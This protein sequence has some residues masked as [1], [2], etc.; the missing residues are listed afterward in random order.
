MRDENSITIDL[1]RILFHIY[2][3]LPIIA[4]VTVAFGLIGFLI[5]AVI[6]PPTYSA[7]AQ[8]LVNNRRDDQGQSTISQSDINASSSLVDTYAIILKSYD[9]LEKV[10]KECS[11]DY[12]FE[13]LSS[14]I[15]VKAVNSTQVMR[16]TVENRNPDEALAICSS[17]VKLAPD[18]IINAIDAGSVSTVS[19]PYTTG[20]PIAPSKRNF[21][22]LGALLG[23]FLSAVYVAIR[24]LTNDRFK[25]TEDI[26]TIL[27]I[28]VL[29]VIP[30]ENT[31]KGT[32]K[33]RS[34]RNRGDK[35][36]GDRKES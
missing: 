10:E 13:D 15:S 29:G 7:S 14:M 2:K 12:A 34:R 4:L 33:K 32:K 11:L 26:R 18:A 22:A 20:K 27:D 36:D 19:S 25:T 8:M 28:N 23:L 24:E 30:E 21:T 9:V 1:G 16:I 3:Q 31:T 17:L 35:I 5:S 6:I